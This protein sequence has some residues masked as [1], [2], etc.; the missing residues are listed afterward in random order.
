MHGRPSNQI[1]QDQEFT[2]GTDSRVADGSVDFDSTEGLD[3]T[4]G[5][6]GTTV[7]DGSEEA[8]A[9]AI[10]AE[11]LAQARINITSL[12][13]RRLGLREHSRQELE[14]WLRGRFRKS[15][16]AAEAQAIIVEVAARL[17]ADGFLSDDR[18]A[19]MM[20]RHHMMRGKGPTFIRMKL[21]E[22]GIRADITQIRA[23]MND[24][25]ATGAEP[26][27][28]DGNEEIEEVSPEAAEIETARRVIERRYPTARTDKKAAARAFQTLMRRGFSSSVARKALQ[29]SAE[30]D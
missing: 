26:L 24:G 15:P 20:T 4:D 21:M 13:N 11:V 17:E 3:G 5:L 7:S 9:G 18:Y 23:W 6:D 2:K 16:I 19:K 1:K 27:N 8:E 10:L 22:K 30:T 29:F 14:R 12:A 25:G 28:V